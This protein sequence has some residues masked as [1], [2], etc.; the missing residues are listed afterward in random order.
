M[1]QSYIISFFL[2]RRTSR[3]YA[4]GKELCIVQS[5][6]V[7]VSKQQDLLV[8]SQYFRSNTTRGYRN[9]LLLSD[10]ILGKTEHD[11]RRDTETGM[12]RR[13]VHQFTIDNIHRKFREAL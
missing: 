3:S 5:V 1:S 6:Q 8:A 11:R 7:V 12:E 2:H 10:I 13:Q 9:T 4:A